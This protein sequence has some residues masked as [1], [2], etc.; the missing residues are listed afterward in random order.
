MNNL[1]NNPVLRRH[2]PQ[3][4]PRGSELVMHVL[5]EYRHMVKSVR[6]DQSVNLVCCVGGQVFDV[7][8]IGKFGD[9]LSIAGKA[10]DGTEF[11]TYAPIELVSFTIIVSNKVKAGPPREIGFFAEMKQQASK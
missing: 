4:T 1:S 5:G 7:Y 6:A 9:I 11:K 8:S 2:I 10:E 3:P